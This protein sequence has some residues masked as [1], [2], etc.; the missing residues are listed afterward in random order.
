M[1]LYVSSRLDVHV[2][3][4][5]EKDKKWSTAPEFLHRQPRCQTISGRTPQGV[6][7]A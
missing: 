6:A 7:R 5:K 2:Q 3:A 1:Y 4:L